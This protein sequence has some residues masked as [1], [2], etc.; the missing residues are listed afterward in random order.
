MAV[1]KKATIKE[2]REAY[3]VAIRNQQQG[4]MIDGFA[5]PTRL[6]TYVM[7]YV[8]LMKIPD[9]CKVID[10]LNNP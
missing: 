1:L 9:D 4:F 10:L 7:E 2:L 6:A 3:N 5:M 8:E